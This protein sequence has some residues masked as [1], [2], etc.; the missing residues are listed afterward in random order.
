M[1]SAGP[2]DDSEL[3]QVPPSM[4][5]DSKEEV[6]EKVFDDFRF[7]IGK[8]RCFKERVILA[9][10]NE[11]VNEAN[12]E[13]VR[14]MPDDLHTFTSVDT[15]GDLENTTMF[16]TEFLNSLSLSGLPEHRL[17][18]KKKHGGHSAQKHEHQ[19]WSLQ[20]DK[21]LGQENWEVPSCSPKIGCCS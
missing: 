14:N 16:P 17:R 8:P 7:H 3:V 12:D 11:V 4:C 2:I 9:A 13:L 6:I 15:V 18:L 10:T 19:S 5:L 21:V 20:R 1:P